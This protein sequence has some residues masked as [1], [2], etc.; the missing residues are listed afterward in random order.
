MPSGEQRLSCQRLP[1][2]GAKLGYWPAGP[3]DGY[4]LT[5]GNP[6]DHLAAMIPQLADRN[7]GHIE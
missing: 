4:L 5:M 1:T 7:L 6:V 3:G 2:Q